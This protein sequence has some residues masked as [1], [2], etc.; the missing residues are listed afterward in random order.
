[1]QSFLEGFKADQ[2]AV[3]YA[4][5]VTAVQAPTAVQQNVPAWLVFGAFFIVIP[6]S[7]TLIRERQS[8][9]LRRLQSST[10]SWRTILASKWVT[11]FVINQL[12]LI[13]MLAVGVYLVPLLGGQALQIHGSLIALELMAGAL[14]VAALGYALLIAAC[15][16]TTE[17]ATLLGGAGNIILAAIGGIMVP[18]FVMPPTMQALSNIS[19]M[20]WGL[21]GFLDVLL[22]DGGLPQIAGKLFA[23]CAFGLVAL[24]AAYYLLQKPSE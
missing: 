4:Y 7:N 9:M 12:Q 8:G 14:S 21:N 3:R 23:L 2:V 24:F 5:N 19:P 22:R 17:Q 18:R 11:F 6:L 20:A 13:F 15:C 16:K 1:M 10:V